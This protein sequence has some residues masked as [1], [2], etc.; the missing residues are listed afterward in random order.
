MLKHPPRSGIHFL[1]HTFNFSWSLHSFASMWKT[2]SIIPIY[3]MRKLLDS[4]AFFRPISLIFASQSFLNASFS[5]GYSSFWN[6]ISFS[7]RAWPVSA[8][9]GLFLIKFCSL[10]SPFRMGL[11]NP[12]PVLGRS[13]LLSIS[14][15]LLTLSGTP[16]YSTNL[17]RL[18]SLLTLPVG[19]NLP[20]L[21]DALVWFFKV[22][23]V[24]P[25]ESVEV[26]RKDPFLAR[27]FLSF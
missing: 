5:G 10:L 12:G 27:T 9:D 1:L 19:L 17:F 18:A 8:L 21:I 4:P 20:F 24:V 16:P 22:T 3:K 7:F 6:L 26:L 13:S 25:F 14:L 11:T 23:K 15:K 2:S